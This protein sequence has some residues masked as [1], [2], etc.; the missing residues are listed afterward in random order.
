ML[1]CLNSLV[2]FKMICFSVLFVMY[3]DKLAYQ[4]S[5]EGN[6]HLGGTV[7]QSPQSKKVPAEGT[8]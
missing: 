5:N 3:L 4:L 1:Q 6:I 8:L 7:S 2:Q